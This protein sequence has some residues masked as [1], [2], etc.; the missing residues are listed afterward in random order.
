MGNIKKA[1]SYAARNG[2]IDTVFASIERKK[3]LKADE[4]VY[5]PVPADVLEKQRTEEERIKISIL[6]PAY[7]TEPS[8][9]TALIDSVLAQTYSDW[10]LLLCDASSSERVKEIVHQYK[11]TRI[12]YH[13]LKKNSG[14]S[15]NTNQGLAYVSG[16]YVA[17]LDH[18]DLLTPDALYEMVKVAESEYSGEMQVKT[19]PYLVYSDEDK[20]DG[21]GE[22]FSCP[23]R[24]LDF[25]LDLF[26]TNNY[27]CHF[28]M[29][30]TDI[31]KELQLRPEYDGAQDYD[32][33]LRIVQLI[34]RMNPSVNASDKFRDKIVHVPK[35]L[36]HWRCHEGS[37]ADNPSSKRYAY[38]AGRRAVQNWYDRMGIHVDVR[39]GKHLGFYQ[40]KYGADI[41]KKRN[42]IGVIGGRI[43]RGGKVTGGAMDKDGN[44]IYGDMPSR[45]N[46]Y[47]NR[48]SL[49][50]DVTALDIRCMEVRPELEQLYTQAL[51]DSLEDG[52]RKASLVFS[53]EVR[54]MGYF[55]LYDPTFHTK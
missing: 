1:L 10:E 50:Q 7:E 17:L 45:F 31:I 55:L 28:T 44:V 29:I 18:D 2:M 48:A 37:T 47:M 39:H 41:F 22:K 26:L 36:Y 34:M 33:F 16:N 52:D 35:I 5:E 6:V 53:E 13:R 38:E 25:N 46:G 51:V 40:V 9:L 54:K 19:L 15:G 8:Y 27:I 3:Q 32:L 12:Q 43:V 14:I 42:D 24:K 49:T 30:R 21:T 23:H 11:D 4:Y 20:C